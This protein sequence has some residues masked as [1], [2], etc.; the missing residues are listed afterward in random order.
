VTFY[1]DGKSLLALLEIISDETLPKAARGKMKVSVI[2]P[3]LR[4]ILVRSLSLVG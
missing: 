1:S 2:D 3:L 4:V